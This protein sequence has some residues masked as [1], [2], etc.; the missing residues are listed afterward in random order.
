MYNKFIIIGAGPAGISA[1][2]ELSKA[3]FEVKIFEK[4]LSVGGLAKT[5]KYGDCLYD[6]GPHRFFTLNK[7]IENFYLEILKQDVTE[8]K[9]LTRILYHN[10]LFLYPL[11]P[12]S[13]I[14]KI[15]FIGSL[16]ITTDYIIS[17]FCK[18]ILKKKPKNFE[19]WVVLNFGKELH[20]KFFKSY[21]EKVWGIDCK[22][23]GKDWA[24]QRIKNLSFIN[25]ILSPIFKIFRKKKIKTR[26]LLKD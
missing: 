21:T 19:D 14:L 9:R 6:I 15:G 16:K 11:S 23:I 17:L 24:A 1:G 3:G 20:Q 5:T 13:T 12:F 10:K 25:A 18:I 4:S 8:V 26:I 22:N 7:E 2:Y